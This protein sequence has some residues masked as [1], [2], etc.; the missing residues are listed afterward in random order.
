MNQPAVRPDKP[1]LL[2]DLDG[3]VFS[4]YET[5]AETLG[6]PLSKFTSI[7]LNACIGSEMAAKC[8]ALFQSTDFQEGLKTY[9]DA[10][11]IL[12]G[13]A[14]HGS[15]E[16]KYVTSCFGDHGNA[17]ARLSTLEALGVAPDDV[18]F[19]SAQNKHLIGGAMLVE[20]NPL[21]LTDF[22]GIRV[23]IDRPWNQGFADE[24]HKIIRL[25]LS[26][27]SVL[28]RLVKGLVR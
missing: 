13:G 24:R 21:A 20:D 6:I 25:K 14:I 12:P 9:P 26:E 3:V 19:A 4:L 5:L 1:I 17:N 18:I 7:D 28:T 27:L 16:V 23:L 11:V 15:W 10:S 2:C 22:P 8:E